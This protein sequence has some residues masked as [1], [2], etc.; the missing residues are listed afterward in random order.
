MTENDSR[1]IPDG[2]TIKAPIPTKQ[3]KALG[4]FLWDVYGDPDLICTIEEQ[5][6]FEK[7]FEI[8]ASPLHRKIRDYLR[9]DPF[10]QF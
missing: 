1:P 10:W 2:F 5:D 8:D 9:S 7:A 4:K 3:D 6:S